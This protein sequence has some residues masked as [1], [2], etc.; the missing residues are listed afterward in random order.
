MSDFNFLYELH[1]Q[2]GNCVVT[3]SITGDKMGTML[4]HIARTVNE[5]G[6]GTTVHMLKARMDENTV[7]VDPARMESLNALITVAI[8]HYNQ[9]RGK[10]VVENTYPKNKKI[11]ENLK[12]VL[13]SPKKAKKLMAE[14]KLPDLE[15]G[16]TLLVGKFKNRKA[17]IEGF[18]TDDNNQPVADTTKGDQKIFKPRIAK[19]MPGAEEKKDPEPVEENVAGDVRK[20]KEKHPENYC[21]NGKCLWRVKTAQ[22]DKPC[23]KHMSAAVKEETVDEASHGQV[24]ASVRANKEKHPENYCSNPKCLWH[25]SSGPCPKHG[26]K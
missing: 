2:A 15:K 17:E 3:Q 14:L 25:T 7:L 8:E 12:R 13:S 16:D 19:L 4:E 24:A 9:K 11:V 10:L 21:T 20:M 1:D 26:K 22:G 6:E 5:T 23:P 18:K